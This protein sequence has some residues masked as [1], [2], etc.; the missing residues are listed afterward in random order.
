MNEHRDAFDD[1]LDRSAEPLAPPPGTFE[2]IARDA[3]RRRIARAC[4]V[5]AVASVV[6][7]GVAA[8]PQL[9]R[10]GPPWLVRPQATQSQQHS[11]A[12][13]PSGPHTRAP[14]PEPTPTRHRSHG[15]GPVPSTSSSGHASGTG[16]SSG[17]T[18]ASP[19]GRPGRC[20]T[21]GLSVRLTRY[22]AGAGQR[23]ATVV[24]TNTSGRTCTLYGYLGVRLSGPDGPLPTD[25]VRAPGTSRRVMLR[26]GGSAATVLRWTVV[27]SGDASEGCGPEP[28]GIAITPPDATTQLHA[29][30]HGGVVCGDGEMHTV[31]LVSGSQAPPI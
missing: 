16:P 22:G 27:P 30:W 5:G 15:P 31:P 17:P 11:T 4:T 28:T 7:V 2:R 29:P 19:T 12:P 13:S 10:S 18:S 23:Y 26:P 8:I 1:W 14:S 20:H 25:L 6:I 21:G 3:R 24:F 9:V